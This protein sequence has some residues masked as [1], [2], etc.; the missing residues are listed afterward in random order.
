MPG[1]TDLWTGAFTD[2]VNL[3]NLMRRKQAQK[4]EPC[5]EARYEAP[6][7][8]VP[9]NCRYCNVPSEVN[10]PVELNSNPTT[11]MSAVGAVNLIE[12]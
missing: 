5:P 1:A 6:C 8:R 7:G 4:S 10:C 11:A 12:P 9:A 3:L 2:D